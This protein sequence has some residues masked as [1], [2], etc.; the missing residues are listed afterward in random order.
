MTRS[1]RQIM[2]RKLMWMAGGA[3][4]AMALACLPV[5]AQQAMKGSNASPTEQ[6]KGK[7]FAKPEDAGAALYAAA[8]RDDEAE[9][10]V[11]LGPDAKKI[12]EW[13][14]DANERREQQ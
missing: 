1:A 12:V 2:K 11:I 10:L 9:L 14:E 13:S 4:I 8:R 7:S 3:V 5:K 6:P